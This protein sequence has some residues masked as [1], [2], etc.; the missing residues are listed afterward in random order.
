MYPKNVELQFVYV[1]TVGNIE[2]YHRNQ[3]H[4]VHA[5]QRMLLVMLQTNMPVVIKQEQAKSYVRSHQMVCALLSL[6]SKYSS[7]VRTG[8]YAFSEKTSQTPYK[9]QKH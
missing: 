2:K 7:M 6:D 4:I 9:T 3:H 1:D 5:S 8:K